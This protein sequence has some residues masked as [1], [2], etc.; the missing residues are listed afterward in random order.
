MM[1]EDI[2]D[3]TNREQTK[4]KLEILRK[5][6]KAWAIIIGSHFPT[7]YFVDCFAGRGKYHLGGKKN[8][9]S[10][11]PL[12]GV[13]TSVEVKAIKKKKGI[14]FNLNVIAI[15]SDKDNIASLNKFLEEIASKCETKIKLFKSEFAS[16]I[17]E[18]VKNIDNIPAFFFID[19][20]GIKGINKDTLD[21]IVNRNGSTEIFFNYMTM[22][23]QRVKGQQKNIDNKDENI[24]ITAIKTVSHMDNFFGDKKWIEK[25]DEELLKHFV[26][27]VFNKNYKFVLNFNVPYS[28][29]SGTIYNLL[30]ATNYSCGEKIMRDIMTAKLFKGTLF[31]DCPLSVDWSIK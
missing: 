27:Q 6:L 15:E 4:I 22:G 20:Y 24:K 18:I 25:D 11:S 10:G 3:I 31:K 21:L 5:Y 13:E 9:V 28:K 16:A 7:A 23:I 29:R 17:P 12:I 19:P 30:F 2:W 26:E 14:D 1:K 8:S